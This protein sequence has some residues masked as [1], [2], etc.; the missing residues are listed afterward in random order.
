MTREDFIKEIEGIA[1]KAEEA[2]EPYIAE[3]LRYFAR[4]IRENVEGTFISMLAI[5]NKYFK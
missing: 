4:L 1:V 5:M 3:G 2:K